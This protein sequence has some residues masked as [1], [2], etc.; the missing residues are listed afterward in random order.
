MKKRHMIGMA[1]LPVV[2]VLIVRL[3]KNT[4]YK[5]TDS[6]SSTE[7]KRKQTL[8]ISVPQQSR[9]NGPYH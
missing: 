5:N 4:I 1:V 7:C 3:E 8:E 9:H 2:Q 6:E